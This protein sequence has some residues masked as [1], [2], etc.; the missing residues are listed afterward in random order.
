[1]QR[2]CERWYSVEATTARL[3]RIGERLEAGALV[4]LSCFDGAA[5]RTEEAG[6][7]VQVQYDM[8]LERLIVVLAP[9]EALATGRQRRRVS[10][11]SEQGRELTHEAPEEDKDT[12]HSQAGQGE[13]FSDIAARRL[14]RREVLKGG[15][16]AAAAAMAAPLLGHMAAPVAAAAGTINFTPIEPTK[17]DVDRVVLAAGHQMAVLIR[18]G[19]P[20]APGAPPFDPLR[21]TGEA[22]SKQFGYD[23][24]FAGYFPLP[25]GSNNSN[26]GLL[27]VNHEYTN[28]ELMFP[29]FDIKNLTREQVEVQLAAIGGSVIEVAKAADSRWSVVANSPY[30]RR[31]TVNTPIDL[32]GPAT[33]HDWV[34]S[35]ANPNGMTVVGTLGACSG[36]TTPWGTVLACE[37]NFQ[38]YFANN[39][40]LA[41]SDPHKGQNVRYGI[42]N[43]AGVYQWEKHL[44]RFDVTQEAN[45]PNRFG[46]VVEV[47]PYNPNFVPVKRTALGRYRHEAATVVIAPSGQAVV[48]SGDDARF[49]YVYKFVSARKYDPTNRE[50]NFGLLDEGTLSVAKFND[51]GSGVWMPIIFGQGPLTPENGFSSQADVLVRT[52]MAADRLGPTKMDRPEDIET[53]PVNKKVYMVMTNNNQRLASGPDG[54][55]KSNPRPDNRNGHILEVTET[56][57]DHAATTFRWDMFLVCGDPK[58]PSTYFAGYPKDKVSALG[59]PDNIV[60]DQEGN[61]WIACDGMP[62]SLKTNDGF[63]AV[64]TEGP[65]RGRVMQFFSAVAGAEMLGPEFTPDNTT[66]FLGIQHP[67][68][69]G[70]FEKPV[71][72]WPDGPGNPPKPS[73]MV[74]WNQNGGRIGVVPGGAPA[75]TGMPSALPRTGEPALSGTLGLAAGAAAVAAGALVRLRSRG[76]RKEQ[77]AAE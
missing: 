43:G 53:N 45:E 58:D 20:V 56:N 60:F 31:I 28:P 48:Y 49:E 44:S 21:Q 7:V 37:E 25:Y 3:F 14:S 67:G 51:D 70:T 54:V 12:I 73:V 59:C 38:D 18:W 77:E 24:D 75:A 64:P 35:S 55:N 65:Q 27:W 26:R 2:S 39:A 62:A 47:D 72:T 52:R 10:S 9:A 36:G 8:W 74:I 6:N 5:V 29:N 34:K 4:G 16:T 69:G 42:P 30:N 22:Q 17:P 23:N 71:S 57:N 1:M 76:Q 13:A 63:Y 19:D 61:L 46:W 32:K 41:D 66:L 50:A 40:R 11:M 33:G 15:I 68:E